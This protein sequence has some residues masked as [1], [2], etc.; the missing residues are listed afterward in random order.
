[1][2]F[3]HHAAQAEKNGAI[4]AAR[5]EFAFKAAQCRQR[6]QCGRLGKQTALKFLLDGAAHKFHCTLNG[7]EH[8]VAHK[9]IGHHHIHFTAKHGIALNIADKIHLAAL[10]QLKG[11][12]HRVGAFDVFRA[13]IEQ[14]D[15]R[16]AFFRIQRLHKLAAD[17][18]KLHQLLGR[19]IHIGAQ[20][21]HQRHVI[22]CRGQK[23]GNGRPLDAGNGFEHKTGSG[24]QRA[25]VAGR[26]GSLRLALFYLIDGHAHGRIFFVFQ[27]QLGRFIHRH[28][29]RGVLDI[30]AR[31]RR[32]RGGQRRLQLRLITH[33]NQACSGLL[34]Q[35]GKCARYGYGQT[36]ITAH[37]IYGQSKHA[38][39][40]DSCC[41]HKACAQMSVGQGNN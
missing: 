24:H 36:G 22:A 15:A 18:G 17:H 32:M 33:H 9:T 11:L 23:F 25:G 41:R 19:A 12:L 14:T 30:D 10:E 31:H 26:H 38:A 21:E 20:I 29:L 3:N 35:K 8:D 4:E 34:F 37:G 28:H 5:V 39:A 27:R 1:M 13:H 40:P 6:H 16:A 2:A 7:F